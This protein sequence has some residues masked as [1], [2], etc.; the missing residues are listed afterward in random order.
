MIRQRLISVHA[1][2]ELIMINFHVFS[3]SHQILMQTTSSGLSSVATVVDSASIPAQVGSNFLNS[4]KVQKINKSKFTLITCF[5]FFLC[6]LQILHLAISF[7]NLVKE[8]EHAG[9]WTRLWMELIWTY[10]HL[11]A[12]IIQSLAKK[13]FPLSFSKSF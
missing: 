2:Q 11:V 10:S 3:F 8:D 7:S 12:L 4:V 13:I 5:F 6:S 1:P 9:I